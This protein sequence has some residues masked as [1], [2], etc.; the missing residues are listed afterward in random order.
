MKKGAVTVKAFIER[1]VGLP[2]DEIS[3]L[4][5][6]ELQNHIEKRTGRKMVYSHKAKLSGSRGNPLLSLGRYK[7][8]EEVDKAMSKNIKLKK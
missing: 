7:T 4:D 1:R 5:S 6:D 3:R 8:M 2:Y